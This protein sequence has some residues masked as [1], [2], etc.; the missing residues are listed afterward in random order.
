[1]ND[2]SIVVIS[3]HAENFDY[4]CLDFKMD[5]FLFPNPNTV[6]CLNG[7]GIYYDDQAPI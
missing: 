7:C 6:I 4:V 3:I 2:L 1:M 5:L